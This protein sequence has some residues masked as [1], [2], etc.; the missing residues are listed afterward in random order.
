LVPTHRLNISDF[1][2]TWEG[3]TLEELA[4]LQLLTA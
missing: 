2:P 1:V 3:F 4:L